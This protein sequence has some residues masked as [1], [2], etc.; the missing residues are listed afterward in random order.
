MGYSEAG[1]LPR[2][3]EHC[4]KEL[5]TLLQH[6]AIPGPYMLV[7]HSMGGAPVR[8]FAHT[9]AAEVAG[10]VLIESTNPREVGTPGPKDVLVNITSVRV[11]QTS[12]AAVPSAA[13]TAFWVDDC[14]R[15]NR[16]RD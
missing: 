13:T 10:V 7:G 6:A 8:V 12:E 9:Y 15:A 3:A 2:T 14:R 1:S 11:K 5:H 4:A 16:R